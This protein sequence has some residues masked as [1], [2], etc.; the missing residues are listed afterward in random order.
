MAKAKR[1]SQKSWRKRGAVLEEAALRVRRK[2]NQ[3]RRTGGS[4]SSLSDSQLFAVD[5]TG[6]NTGGTSVSRRKALRAGAPAKVLHVD[7]MVAT[8]PY[9][10]PVVKAPASSAKP[11][12]LS[13]GTSLVKDKIGKARDKISR[14]LTHRA[15]RAAALAAAAPAPSG[16]PLDIWGAAPPSSSAPAFKVCQRNAVRCKPESSIV[17]KAIA[18]AP[19]GASWNPSYDSHQELLAAATEHELARQRKEQHHRFEPLFG[20]GEDFEGRVPVPIPPEAL[21]EDGAED[22]EDDDDDEEDSD[23]EEEEDGDE[24]DDGEEGGKAGR[25]AERSAVTEAQRKKRERHKERE[26]LAAAAK[27]EKRQAAELD[28]VEHVLGEIKRDDKALRK[29]QQAEAEWE[30][31]RPK[32]LGPKRHEPKR[33]DVLLTE[34]LPA[35]L[36]ALEPEGSLLEDRLD[37]MRARNMVEV[38]ERQPPPQKRKR[39][40][41][42]TERA[43]EG[44]YKS[45]F[46][47]AGPVPA[48]V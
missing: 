4:I 47:N 30:A 44:Q 33:P 27:R 42:L 16:N 2:A 43:K 29:K 22:S 11:S 35:S 8:N 19:D 10:E 34:E 23:A 38:R 12:A 14:T 28:R 3:E 48:W 46:G 18:P 45:P 39:R 5:A 32:K 7:R 13:R 6:G 41:V 17:T 15:A 40:M 25:Q 36:R 20:T 31:M 9:I 24:D 37:S 26:R 1:Q 21:R